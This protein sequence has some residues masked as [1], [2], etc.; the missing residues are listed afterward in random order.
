MRNETGMRLVWRQQVLCIRSFVFTWRCRTTVPTCHL[1]GLCRSR[2]LL[3]GETVQ[4]CRPATFRGST[5]VPICHLAG[6]CHSVD[7][8][9]GYDVPQCR[10]ATWRGSAAVRIWHLAGPCRSVDLPPCETL[11][12]CHLP[13]LLTTPQAVYSNML[14]RLFCNILLWIIPGHDY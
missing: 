12:Q 1:A 2:D 14:D 6:P 3:P 9:P 5:A 8:P 10:P 7:L 13:P 4:Q 11:P